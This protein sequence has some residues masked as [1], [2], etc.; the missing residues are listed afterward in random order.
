MYRGFENLLKGRSPLDA[1]VIAPRICGICSTGQLAAAASALDNLCAAE[2][3]PNATKLR[4]ITQM[5]EHIQS[6]L[7]QS[8]LM[9]AADFAS[10]TFADRSWFDEAVSRYEPFKGRTVIETVRCSKEVLEIIAIVGGQWPHSAYMVPGGIASSPTRS[11]IQQCRFI[12][13]KC[14]SWYERQVLGCSLSRWQAIGSL[15]DLQAWLEESPAHAEGELGFFLRLCRET[16]LDSLGRSPGNFIAFGQLPLP[17]G[18]GVQSRSGGSSL[19]PAGFAEGITLEPFDHSAVTETAAAAWYADADGPQHPWEAETVPYASG[20]E[21]SKYSWIKAPRYRGRPAETG[22]L[23]EMVVSGHTLFTD[24]VQKL[25]SNVFTRQLARLV[26]PAELFPAMRTWLDEINVRDRFYIPVQSIPDGQA[27]GLTHAPRGALGHWLEVRDGRIGSYQVITP[28]TWNGSPRDEHGAA[29][30]W[31]EALQGTVLN[32][33]EDPV[34]LG[35]IVRSFDPCLV[36]S[37]HALTPK[38]RRC[39]CLG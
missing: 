35:Q 9:F 2:I 16:Q 29:G 24:L 31:E 20:R 21:G 36:C 27:C 37:V 38:G 3:P 15:A 26:R 32:N 25:G 6:D 13:D 10:S 23:A 11:D 28:T 1:L 8:F 5:A 7:R 22:P 34:E 33:T 17:E 19:I 4:N 12:L 30:P 14:Q 39:W 18:S